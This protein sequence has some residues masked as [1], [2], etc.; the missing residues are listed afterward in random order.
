ML[1]VLDRAGA[2]E[3]TKAYQDGLFH[4]GYFPALLQGLGC[5]AGETVFDLCAAPGGKS[6]TVAERMRGEESVCSFDL[7]PPARH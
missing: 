7:Y 1:L 2:I 3:R 6:F 4:A 5:P